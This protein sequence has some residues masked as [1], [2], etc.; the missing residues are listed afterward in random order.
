ME[1]ILDKNK[2]EVIEKE[3]IKGPPSVVKPIGDFKTKEL[4]LIRVEYG[5]DVEG[6]Y[7]WHFSSKTDRRQ[8]S[9]D[10]KYLAEVVYTHFHS[11]IPSDCKVEVFFPNH[12]FDIRILTVKGH[13]LGKKWSF[14]EDVINSTLPKVCEL[15][16]LKM[17]IPKAWENLINRGRR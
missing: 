8:L 16:S 15:L 11:H 5:F 10:N 9:S 6:N 7:I 4:S 1:H 14:D 12:T 13:N 3:L 17:D 2:K